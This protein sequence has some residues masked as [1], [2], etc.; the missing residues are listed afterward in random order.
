MKPRA[1]LHHMQASPASEA[2]RRQPPIDAATRHA[3]LVDMSGAPTPEDV[4]HPYGKMIVGA[5]ADRLRR[6]LPA[7][8]KPYPYQLTG[9]AFAKLT[10]Y[11]CLIA[12]DMGL[13]KSLTCIGTFVFDPVET[14]PAVVVAPSNVIYVWQAELKKWAPHL[15]VVVLSKRSS[16]LPPKG[17]KGVVIT[18]FGLLSAHA[19]ALG[20]AGFRTFVVDEAHRIKNAQ[21]QQ[22]KAALTVAAHVEHVMLVTGTPLKNRIV[23]LHALLSVVADFGD[24]EEFQEEHSEAEDK[25]LD[26]GRVIRTY[27][28]S[29][30]VDELREQLKTVMVR[31]LKQDVAKFLPPKTRTYI[32]VDLSVDQRRE[33]TRAEFDFKQAMKDADP[34]RKVAAALA[35]IGILRQIVGRTKVDAAVEQIEAFIENELP[36]IVFAVHREVIIMLRAALDARGI[37]YAVIDGACPPKRRR[38]IVAAFQA[39]ELEVVIGSEAMKEGIT[40]TRASDVMFV[41]RFWSPAD[42][43][44][45][46]DRAHRIGSINAVT[47][48]FLH[49]NGTIDDRIRRLIDKKRE[50]SKK[51]LGG[52]NAAEGNLSLSNVSLSEFLADVAENRYTEAVAAAAAAGPKKPQHQLPKSAIR[53]LLFDPAKW[54]PDE[55]HR[56]TGI[57]GLTP[58]A[59]ETIGGAKPRL[60]VTTS[61]GTSTREKLRVIKVAEG[62][63]AIVAVALLPGA[64][65]APAPEPPKPPKKRRPGG[66]KKRRAAPGARTP[67]RG[68]RR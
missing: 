46:E 32:P 54:K 14:L 56:W 35:Q 67:P 62:V 29:K 38:D 18:S 16:P 59:L 37:R 57:N 28:G 51:V 12:D 68:S 45:A 55:A 66:H 64:V 48:W 15:S 44:Q 7:I 49:A 1:M 36:L 30:N 26:N 34:K 53:A 58:L 6:R 19:G 52:D 2:P 40:L 3:A 60:R 65:H 61:Y 11:C 63:S 24:T 9:M 22:T 43:M 23:E 39:G 20:R 8:A 5:I 50:L 27:S 31:R 33:Y 17:F 42:E 25:Q 10:N 21:A 41:E 47:I 13:G 4:K